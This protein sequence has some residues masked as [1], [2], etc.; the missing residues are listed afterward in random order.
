MKR[1]NVKVDSCGIPTWIGE[2]CDQHRYLVLYDTRT[3]RLLMVIYR[4]IIEMRI[5]ETTL[6]ADRE[7]I[8]EE[9]F[10]LFMKQ[11]S[12]MPAWLG[13]M[14]IYQA[15]GQKIGSASCAGGISPDERLSRLLMTFIVLTDGD[16]DDPSVEH[17]YNLLGA[18]WESCSDDGYK[19]SLY[20]GFVATLLTQARRE[21]VALGESRDIP[22]A[23]TDEALLSAAT[24]FGGS[25]E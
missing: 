7:E 13:L 23:K 14:W 16:P 3:Y 10:Q 17:F 9:F 1:N 5:P 8:L 2:S 12:S 24:Y 4:S 15:I 6:K 25:E 22:E 20:R 19:E 21:L 18:G 11:G